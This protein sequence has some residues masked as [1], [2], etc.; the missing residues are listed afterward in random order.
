MLGA[1][2]SAYTCACTRAHA[3]EAK[4]AERLT[5]VAEGAGPALLTTR[6]RKGCGSG[7]ASEGA[8]AEVLGEREPAGAGAGKGAGADAGEA[9]EPEG[10]GLSRE[11]STLPRAHAQPSS[12]RCTTEPAHA[13]PP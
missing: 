8:D 11:A 2:A 4:W 1:C 3:N 12:G 9:A 7:A 6:T 5:C 10:D 13:H